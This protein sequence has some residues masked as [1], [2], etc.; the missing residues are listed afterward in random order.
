MIKHL[1]HNQVDFLLIGIVVYW[2]LH[3]Q[4][5][6]FAADLEQV[7]LSVILRIDGDDSM[8]HAS[9]GAIFLDRELAADELFSIVVKLVKLVY[10]PGRSLNFDRVAVEIDTVWINLLMNLQFNLSHRYYSGFR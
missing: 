5:L 3:V 10:D 2:V 6:F 1:S 4:A 8:V 9:I 7:L